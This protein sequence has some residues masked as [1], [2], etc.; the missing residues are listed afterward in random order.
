MYRNKDNAAVDAILR[1]TGTYIS[2]SAERDMFG[3]VT[4]WINKHYQLYGR[5]IKPV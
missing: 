3:L 2:P 4:H 5:T 1:A